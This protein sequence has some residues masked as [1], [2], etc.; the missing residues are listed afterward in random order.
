MTNQQRLMIYTKI[1][2]VLGVLWG[3]IMVWVA[4]Q[5]SIITAISVCI[6]VIS[7]LSFI[8]GES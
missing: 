7:L 3:A 5:W 4:P 2:F 6:G 1:G 8:G